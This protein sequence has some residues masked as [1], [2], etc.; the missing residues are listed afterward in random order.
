M[1]Y[2][3]SKI[4]FQISSIDNAKTKCKFRNLKV[5]LIRHERLPYFQPQAICL[6]QITRRKNDD[7]I[8]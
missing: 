5:Q 6:L 3:Q 2:F 4:T 1:G 8:E 7:T